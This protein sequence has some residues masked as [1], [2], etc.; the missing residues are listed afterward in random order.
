MSDEQEA[1]ERISKELQ[2]AFKTAVEGW[3]LRAQGLGEVAVEWR[4]DKGA[5]AT[6]TVDGQPFARVWTEIN[7][8]K[9][10]V[11]S[12]GTHGNQW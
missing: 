8:G 3:C 6:V 12:Q 1:V 11:N 5:T 7:C 9:I 10:S 4:I 2:D